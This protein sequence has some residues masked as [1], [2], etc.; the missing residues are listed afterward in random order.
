MS[1]YPAASPSPS[2]K[3]LSCCVQP[4]V[5]LH[6]DG[7]HD[8]TLN[9]RRKTTRE[10]A[11]PPM[12]KIVDRGPESL[13]VHDHPPSRPSFSNRS[14]LALPPDNPEGHHTCLNQP[15]AE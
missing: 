15:R 8:G 13:R 10:P 7:H 11:F 2:P 4:W 14:D 6:F 9:R 3:P 12:S 5:G 1:T